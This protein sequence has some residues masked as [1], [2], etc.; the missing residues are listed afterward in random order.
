MADFREANS[1]NIYDVL[2]NKPGRVFFEFGE[3]SRAFDN[4]WRINK[5]FIFKSQC[6]SFLFFPLADLFSGICGKLE[7][8]RIVGASIRGSCKWCYVGP[9]PSQRP[10]ESAVDL[11]NSP[12]T[13]AITTDTPA[14][15]PVAD[16]R[17]AVLHVLHSQ[18][19]KIRITIVV[20]PVTTYNA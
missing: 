16:W 17:Q 20:P 1:N 4:V 15:V 10:V 5:I 3:D 14:W 6:L 18:D 2:T 9:L 13:S 19:I 12:S 11:L 8:E 7:S